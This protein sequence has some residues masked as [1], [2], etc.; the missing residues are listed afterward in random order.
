MHRGRLAQIQKLRQ[1][2][3][4][5]AI[6]LVLGSED[7]PELARM[8]HQDP[9]TQRP[10]QVVEVA[11]PAT[12]LVANL[13]AIR[14]V[15]EDLH[16]LLDPSHPRAVGHLPSLAQRA[17]RNVLR[18]NIETDV[19]HDAPPESENVKINQLLSR[20]QLDRGFLHSFT[21]RAIRFTALRAPVTSTAA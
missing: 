4:V 1:P 13:E 15:L 9:R 20:Y 11:I 7:Q 17:D 16:H 8:R 6:V 2:L 3:R 10:Q 5:V 14:Q 21:P 12:G 18:V 19:K